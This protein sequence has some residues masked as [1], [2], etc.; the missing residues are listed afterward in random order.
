I[1]LLRSPVYYVFGVGN[2]RCIMVVKYEM[3][4]AA[5]F[6]KGCVKVAGTAHSSRKS[7]SQSKDRSASSRAAAS[8][9]ANSDS[10]RAR[11]A[12]RTWV[13]RDIP[14]RSNCLATVLPSSVSLGHFAKN[15][16]EA[17]A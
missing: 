7:S 2:V 16:I 10:E 12:S 4:S 17:A 13:A 1:S 11:E 8:F 9:E 5:A 14:A 6:S 15:R 3:S